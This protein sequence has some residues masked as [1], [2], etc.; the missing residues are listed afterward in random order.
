MAESDRE[1]KDKLRNYSLKVY[2]AFSVCDREGVQ[3][4]V[5]QFERSGARV[6]TSFEQQGIM[7]SMAFNSQFNLRCYRQ[8]FVAFD[9]FCRLNFIFSS[10]IAKRIYNDAQASLQAVATGARISINRYVHLFYTST[11]EFD[12]E[13]ID[14]MNEFCGDHDMRKYL[15]TQLVFQKIMLTCD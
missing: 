2:Y 14:A 4:Q 6:Q 5:E 11:A 1:L 15:I 7:K 13:M 12:K 10:K 8:P 9:N 3:A